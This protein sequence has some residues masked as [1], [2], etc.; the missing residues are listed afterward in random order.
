M[1]NKLKIIKV[2]G[3]GQKFINITGLGI[4]L[5]DLDCIEQNNNN[6]KINYNNQNINV[7]KTSL[8]IYNII[9][10][11]D[12]IGDERFKNIN[13]LTAN[14]STLINIISKLNE[15]QYNKFIENNLIIDV[16]NMFSGA[17]K[18]IGNFNQWQKTYNKYE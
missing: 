8:S 5:L 2:I 6:L 7:D 12:Y 14:Y 10:S 4:G 1:E 11:F 15:K 16:K 13:L 18:H 9:L 17:K 3:K